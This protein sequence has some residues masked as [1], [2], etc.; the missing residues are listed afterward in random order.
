MKKFTGLFLL[1][2]TLTAGCQPTSS[3]SN[4]RF[5]RLTQQIAVFQND[6]A[7]VQFLAEEATRAGVRTI[8]PV[9]ADGVF[10]NGRRYFYE[11]G[12]TT[13]DGRIYL[14]ANSVGGRSVVNITH[15]IAHATRFGGRCGG[16]NQ[17]WLSAYLDIAERFEQRFPG[18][19]W[20]GT[21]P[22]QRVLRNRARYGIGTL[23]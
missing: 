1:A 20:S 5:E 19:R 7:I 3:G 10:L 12:V 8:E 4:Q 18:V 17:A 22:T 14:N 2:F 6:P 9:P 23:C 15:E 16:H 11:Y 13:D 21:T